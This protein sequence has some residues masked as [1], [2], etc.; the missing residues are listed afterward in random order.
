MKN[1]SV[2]RRVML[3]IGLLLIVTFFMASCAHL[4]VDEVASRS[5]ATVRN[6]AK[7]LVL[8]GNIPGAYLNKNKNQFYLGYVEVGS[9]RVITGMGPLTAANVKAFADEQKKS[10][11]VVVLANE[12]SYDAIY[13]GLLNLHN[14]TKQNVLPTWPSAKGQFQNRFEWRAWT[15]YK[16]SVSKNMNPWITY[17]AAMNCAA[18]RWSN[19][20]NMINGTVYLQGPSSCINGF[21]I[22]KVEDSAA[23]V[24][25]KQAVQAPTDLVYPNEMVYVWDVLRKDIEGGMTYEQALLKDIKFH[26]AGPEIDKVTV[27]NIDT[28]E[29]VKILS[30][31]KT[32]ETSCTKEVASLHPKF[33]R[34]V[35]FIHKNIAGKKEYIKSAGRS[36]IIAHLAEGRRKDPYNQTEYQLIKLLGLNQPYVNFIHGVGLR[37]DG[38]AGNDPSDKKDKNDDFLDMAKHGMGLIWSPYSNLLLY[39]ETLDIEA[40]NAAGVRLAIGSDWVPTGTKSVLEEIKL[41]A[42]YVDRTPT[43]DGK[44][45]L[46][47]IFTDEYLYKMMT[48]N[49]AQMINHWGTAPGEAGVGQLAPGAMGSVIAVSISNPNPYTNLVRNATEREVNLVVVD[50]NP[51]YGN[52]NYLQQA[53]YSSA[54]YEVFSN[55]ILIENQVEADQ[56]AN[57]GIPKPDLTKLKAPAI[58]IDDND[59]DDSEQ[60]TAEAGALP[61][62]EPFLNQLAN[63]ANDR[64]GIIARKDAC[65]FKIAKAFVTPDSKRY[66]SSII[67]FERD[68]H[69]DLDRVSDIQ[70]LLAVSSMT[71]SL[72]RISPDGDPKF[73]MS[74]FPNL[75]TCSDSA[76]KNSHRYNTY[77]TSDGNDELKANLA[78]RTENR[79]GVPAKAAALAAQYGLTFEVK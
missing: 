68:T 53:G 37:G 14:H 56:F 60:A 33:V 1:M 48:E 21:G 47:S 58:E 34:Y 3:S 70:L 29:G 22:Y 73:A 18:F 10:K 71:Q 38:I 42:R 65:Q 52:V 25:A 62:E 9:D 19:L 64:K 69:L 41:A 78:K 46:N 79:K 4:G 15:N 11:S 8:I 36:A 43:R 17:G 45:K 2:I 63:V 6:A 49:S 40:A 12:K 75:Y 59:A 44:R 31:K 74:Y 30:N 51:I 57:T 28:T 7:P 76:E 35:Y 72:N 50:G 27:S 20:Q 77:V 55:E 23:Y 54:Q 16:K 26:C 61:Q 32:I 39:G 13:P 24:S 67:Q 5:V 66:E